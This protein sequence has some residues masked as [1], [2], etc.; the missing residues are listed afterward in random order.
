MAN[1]NFVCWDCRK[2]VRADP[3]SRPSCPLCQQQMVC[4]GSRSRPPKRR[5]LKG[6]SQLRAWVNRMDG[7]SR[8]SKWAFLANQ[9]F[10]TRWD[11]LAREQR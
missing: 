9:S 11:R 5:D 4:I 1:R 7:N 10:H 8:R 6:W 2:A 3:F